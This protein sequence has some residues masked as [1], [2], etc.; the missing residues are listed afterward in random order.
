MKSCDWGVGGESLHLSYS[1]ESAVTNM[2]R[3]T[4]AQRTEVG[5]SSEA[6]CRGK[7]T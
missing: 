2:K 5:Y 1:R 3:A 7:R 6:I 4:A